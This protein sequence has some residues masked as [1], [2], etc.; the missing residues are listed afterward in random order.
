M[1]IEYQ[2]IFLGSECNNHCVHCKYPSG[3]KIPYEQICEKINNTKDVHNVLLYGGE[4]L[5]RVDIL[6][7]I[8][9]LGGKRIKIVTNGRLLSYDKVVENLIKHNALI[10]EIKIFGSDNLTHDS[11]TRVKNSYQQMLHGIKN[12]RKIT[13]FEGR[14]LRPF[15]ILRNMINKNNYLQLEEI[16]RIAKNL[17]VDR[18][19]LELNDTNLDLNALWL[20][21]KKAIDSSMINRIWCHTLNIPLCIGNEYEYHITELFQK[22]PKN[23]GYLDFC[24]ECIFMNICPGIRTELITGGLRL[25][26]ILKNNKID[27]IINMRSI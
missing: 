20:N 18:L 6:D 11:E 1:L 9:R 8:N 23:Y 7:F 25:N 15:I 12:I 14:K 27:E 2:E 21:V 3:K 19:V 4:P 13:Y 24:S 22:S 26:P 10:Y 16:T 17:D 5:L